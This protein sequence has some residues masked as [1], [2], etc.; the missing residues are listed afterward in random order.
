MRHGSRHLNSLGIAATAI[1]MLSISATAGQVSPQAPAGQA[2]SPAA[3]TTGTAAISG[4]VTDAVTGLPLA[5][6]LVTLARTTAM[7][8]ALPRMV[9]DSRGRFVFRNLPAAPNYYLGAR[10][11]GYAYTRYGWTSPGGSLATRDILQIGLSEGQWLD[12]VNIPLW[13]LG[14][15]AGRVVDERNEPVV[16]VVVRAFSTVPI[17]GQPQLAA[18]PL[19]TTDDRGVY[20]VSGLEPGRYVVSVLSVQSTVLSSTPEAPQMRPV[21]ELDSGGIGGGRGAFVTAPGIDVDGRHRLVMTNFATP[22]APRAGESR[23]YPPAFFAGATTATEATAIEIAYGTSRS[24]IDF[25]LR[26]VLRVS[27]V[28]P[29]GRHAGHSARA[30]AAAD[31]GRQRAAG[32]RVGGRDDGGRGGRHVHVLQRP[33]RQL[34]DPRASLGHGLHKRQQ[35]DTHGRRARLPRRRDLGRVDDRRAR[36][37]LSD[38]QWPAVA[39]VGTLACRCRS[40]EP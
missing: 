11:F 25:Q 20:R 13:R 4:T 40:T 21:G 34:H 32:L 3:A 9:T 12:T 36:P 22:P 8:Q 33:G 14:S 30:S 2:P 19:A 15:I 26:P 16:G 6:A 10:R 18:G 29:G 24:G 7:A 39:D 37:E 38:A 35:L 27:R 1:A 5:G 17:A 28:G 23:A 31:A